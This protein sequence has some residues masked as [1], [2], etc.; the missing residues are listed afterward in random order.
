MGTRGIP[1]AYGGFETFAEEL[2][3]RLV[4][5]G[6]RVSVYCRLLPGRRRGEKFFRGVRLLWTPTLHHKYLETPLH[7]LTSFVDAL[8]RRFDAALVCNAANSPFVWILRLRGIPVVVNVDGVER[9]RA[10]WNLL[11][12]LWYR[13][14]EVCSV[15]F[16]SRIV[17]DAQVIADYYRAE[18][19]A[20]AAVIAYGAEA[21]EV[22]SC[23]TLSRFGL[24]PARYLLY[25]SRLEPENNALGVI[26]AYRRVK[27]DMPLV[28]VGDAP[29]AD[30]Y[31]NKLKEAADERVIFTGYQF[32][33]GYRELRAGCYLYV[34]ASEVG[35]THPA[36]VEAMAYGNCVLANCVPEHEEV[37][38]QAGF[39]Y[40]RNDFEKLTELMQELVLDPARVREAGSLARARAA[41]LYRWDGVVDSYEAL[42]SDLLK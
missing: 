33:E 24:K 17:A 30:G 13:L 11:G 32:G 29:F 26:E 18:Y 25:V 3:T 12:R 36:L 7:G 34:Q 1:A 14:G 40:P 8:F 20:G 22:S 10:K 4:G 15:L 16:A 38:G 28:L 21:R 42:I 2:G 31:I 39:Y 5:R 9:Q 41:Q 37:L 35:G 23:E 27:T 6:H 19:S